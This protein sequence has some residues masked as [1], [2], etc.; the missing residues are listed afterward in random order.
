MSINSSA[1]VMRYATGILFTIAWVLILY[2][3]AY[4][5]HIIEMRNQDLLDAIFP[6]YPLLFL[7]LFAGR[8]NSTLSIYDYLQ[9][10]VSGLL[11]A[12]GQYTGIQCVIWIGGIWLGLTLIKAFGLQIATGGKL[13]FLL[14]PPFTHK[15]TL[16]FGFPLRLKLTQFSVQF[17]KILDPTA[18][19]RGNI[20]N[21]QEGVF[22]VDPACEGLKMLIATILLFLIIQRRY[23]L[24][25]RL[26]RKQMSPKREGRESYQNSLFMNS[27]I[28]KNIIPACIALLVI[29]LWLISNLIRII[30]LVI[31]NIPPESPKHDFIGIIIFLITVAF[32][33]LVIY[34]LLVP[35]IDISDHTYRNNP[36]NGGEINWNEEKLSHN[37]RESLACHHFKQ[38]SKILCNRNTFYFLYYVFSYSR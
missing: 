4:N 3:P 32:P 38:L 24:Q 15:S 6:F 28:L 21:F 26:P 10:G 36:E 5:Y 19:A 20:I 33:I 25:F 22:S 7:P 31:G 17:L 16:V 37:I 9:I 29:V 35:H 11:C 8:T 12:A 2:R 27:H 30:I 1:R 13:L 23:F 34:E 14:T 18:V